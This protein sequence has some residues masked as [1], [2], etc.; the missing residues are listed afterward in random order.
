MAAVQSTETQSQS[1]SS[2]KVKRLTHSY[3]SYVVS[4][5]VVLFLL[6]KQRQRFNTLLRMRKAVGGECLLVA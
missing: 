4:I 2:A 6:R 3:I 5:K 1:S